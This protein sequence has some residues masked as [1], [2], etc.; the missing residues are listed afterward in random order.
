MSQGSGDASIDDENAHA[1]LLRL[2]LS[3][4][5]D[6]AP[7]TQRGSLTVDFSAAAGSSTSR[8]SGRAIRFSS[9]DQTIDARQARKLL[10]AADKNGRMDAPLYRVRF[11]AEGQDDSNGIIA[12]VPLCAL[13]G[14]HLHESFVLHTDPYGALFA[15]SYRTPHSD[16]SAFT[17]SDLDVALSDYDEDDNPPFLHPRARVSFG[18]PGEKAKMNVRHGLFDPLAPGAAGAA[19]AAGQ[20][21]SQSADATTQGG[22]GGEGG[23]DANQQQ[24]QQSFFS[25]YW[26]YIVPLGIFMLMQGAMAPPESEGGGGGRGGG[27]GA[28]RARAQ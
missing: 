5:L 28:A 21:P 17:L 19:A 3:H 7:F 26:M 27:A 1:H 22:Q 23:Q 9:A 11:T 14:S 18:R 6:S 15:V 8:N 25:K 12:S 16:C 2:T 24:P 13:I 4:A 20:Q 10:T